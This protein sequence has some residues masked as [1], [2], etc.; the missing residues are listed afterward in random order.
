MFYKAAKIKFQTS[1]IS[2]VRAGET[3]KKV[4]FCQKQGRNRQE[5]QPA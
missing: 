5:R 1:M 3:K 4:K 2:E